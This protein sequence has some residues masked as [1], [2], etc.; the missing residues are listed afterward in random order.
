M[1]KKAAR[2]SVT[3]GAAEGGDGGSCLEGQEDNGGGKEEEE[4]LGGRKG[5]EGAEGKGEEE[6][7][8]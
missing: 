1:P 5:A 3:R 7:G 8:R 6:E 2:F 4:V